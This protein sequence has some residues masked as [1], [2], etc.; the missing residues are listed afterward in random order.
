M[1]GERRLV[2]DGT[3]ASHGCGIAAQCPPMKP[4]LS[5]SKEACGS[6]NP[7]GQHFAGRIAG[8]THERLRGFAFVVGI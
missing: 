6:C 8:A 2:L 3:G 5:K 1:H 4:L 7:A